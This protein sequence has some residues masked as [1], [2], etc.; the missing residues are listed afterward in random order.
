M[1]LEKT[2]D[3]LLN[4]T[5]CCKYGTSPIN[6]SDEECDFGKAIKTL[7]NRPKGEWIMFEDVQNVIKPILK[8]FYGASESD[9]EYIIQEIEQKAYLE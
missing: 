5:C 2:K 8:R 7:C 3:V 1:T 9:I 6:C 4:Y